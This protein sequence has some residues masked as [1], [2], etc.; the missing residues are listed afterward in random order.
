MLEGYTEQMKGN[1]PSALGEKSQSIRQDSVCRHQRV[2]PSQRD[3][4]TEFQSG[5]ET[6]YD[7]K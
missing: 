5:Q 3:L 1:E 2:S 7:Q 4:V 6:S